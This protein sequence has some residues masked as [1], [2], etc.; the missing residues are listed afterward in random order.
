MADV[1]TTGTIDSNS[2]TKIPK[3]T[4]NDGDTFLGVAAI[5]TAAVVRQKTGKIVLS[6][7][8]NHKAFRGANSKLLE[9]KIDKLLAANFEATERYLNLGKGEALLFLLKVDDATIQKSQIFSE[10]EDRRIRSGG[11]GFSLSD[12][13]WDFNAADKPLKILQ[14]IRNRLGM[15]IVVFFHKDVF[16]V[17]TGK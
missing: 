14:Q 4:N 2:V 10:E 16:P 17:G 3:P 15:V 11:M 12:R 5:G 6:S 9:R 8:N 1:W 7:C 13:R